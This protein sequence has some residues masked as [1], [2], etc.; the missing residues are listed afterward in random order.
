MLEWDGSRHRWA[1]VMPG[2]VFRGHKG[3]QEFARQYYEMWESLEDHVEQLIDAGE[4]VISIVR[5]RG[6]GRASGLDGEWRGDV[7]VCTLRD[8]RIVRVVWF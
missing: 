5:T 8:G 2:P 7:G 6:R 4:H 1:E 3:L